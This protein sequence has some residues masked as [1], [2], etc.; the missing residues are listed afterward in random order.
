VNL[1]FNFLI[2]EEEKLFIIRPFG[3]T[4]EIMQVGA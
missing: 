3:G 2:L 4:Q 1:G